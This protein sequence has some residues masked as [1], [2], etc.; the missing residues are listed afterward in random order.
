[1]WDAYRN[2]YDWPEIDPIRNEISLCL[3]FGLN[4]AAITLTNH[5]LENLLKTTL[6]AYH[7]KDKFPKDSEG[8]VADLIEMTREE[9]VKY[10]NM[11]LGNCINAVRS[12]GLINKDQKKLLHEIRDSFRNAFGHFNCIWFD[13]LH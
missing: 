5:L 6:I 1:M 4:Q 8:K 13:G 3:M 12:A 9:R 7:S 2:A 11:A 10:G